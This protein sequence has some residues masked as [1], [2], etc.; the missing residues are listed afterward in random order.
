MTNDKQLKTQWEDEERKA[1]SG[2]DFSHLDA[3]WR[4]ES[5]PW[6]YKK[7]SANIYCPPINFWTWARAAVNFCWSSIILTKIPR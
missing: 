2:W 6:D 7:L 3:R 4:C 1:F 5:L